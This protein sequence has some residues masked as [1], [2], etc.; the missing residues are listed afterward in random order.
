MTSSSFTPGRYHDDWNRMVDT[1]DAIP[2]FKSAQFQSTFVRPVDK[3]VR[4]TEKFV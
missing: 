2:D 3:V 4:L 1:I